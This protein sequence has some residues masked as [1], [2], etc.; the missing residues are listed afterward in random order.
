MNEIGPSVAPGQSMQG[1][2]AE[3]GRMMRDM[4]REM[5]ASMGD[6]DRYAKQLDS[7]KVFQTTR[8][9]KEFRDKF[10]T[11]MKA[12]SEI[13][14]TTQ[15]TV[16]DAM[17][18]FTD[19]RQQ[20]FYT[21][22][23]IKSQAAATKAREMTTGISAATYGAVGGAGAATARAYGMR[24]RFGA[25]LA[26]QNVAG[27]S[28]GIRS[29][30]MSEEEVME[31]GGVEAVGMRMSQQQMGFLR[32]SRGRAMLA[33]GMGGGGQVSQ[34]RMAQMLTGRGGV[35]QIVT[36]ASDRGLG[37]LMQAGT[38]EARE[39]AVPYA[40]MMMINM[41]MRQQRE[42]GQTVSRRGIV[43]MMGTMGVGRQEA[44]I[45]LQQAMG[46]PEQMRQERNAQ[47]F[48]ASQG[49]EA[50]L[51][52]EYSIGAR[53]GR[54][55]VGQAVTGAAR[56]LQETGGLLRQTGSQMYNQAM[57][58][59]T[60]GRVRT[61]SMGAETQ[62]ALRRGSSEFRYSTYE[63]SGTVEPMR[64]FVR[65]HSPFRI[66]PASDR[67]RNQYDDMAM[68]R[69]EIMSNNVGQ[70][71]T[72]AASDEEIAERVARGEF[73]DLGDGRLVKRTD[74]DKMDAI[75]AK[76]G[77]MSARNK[78]NLQ[79]SMARSD[80]VDRMKEMQ[81]DLRKRRGQYPEGA[82]D[83]DF[84]AYF[85]AV[86]AGIL[87]PEKSGGGFGDFMSEKNAD[88]RVRLKELVAR[89]SSKTQGPN[90]EELMGISRTARPSVVTEADLEKA[91]GS[92]DE[93][94]DRFMRMASPGLLGART[95]PLGISRG[96]AALRD[97]LQSNEGNV[98][99]G[100]NELMGLMGKTDDTSKARKLQL[101]DDL[102]GKM[103]P[104]EFKAIQD[105]YD[106]AEKDPEWGKGLGDSMDPKKHPSG[107]GGA[108]KRLEISE[109]THAR[110]KRGNK[111]VENLLA[112]GSF[113]DLRQKV[114]EF[115]EMGIADRDDFLEEMA[116]EFAVGGRDKKAGIGA[117]EQAILDAFGGTSAT[118]GAAG[119]SAALNAL[120]EGGEAGKAMAKKMGIT[121][122]KG[123]RGEKM[124]AKE[125]MGAL[126]ASGGTNVAGFQGG[127]G[128]EKSIEGIQKEYVEANTI[129]VSAVHTFASQVSSVPGMSA[130]V[131][132]ISAAP[133]SEGGADDG[134]K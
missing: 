59:I 78:T 104:L 119:L 60:G 37:T 71:E 130:W 22:A 133:G 54:T 82:S 85:G 2:G 101:L 21:T 77:Q 18:M 64:A 14:K 33:Y 61:R 49:R 113:E 44:E 86:E 79:L 90:R 124:S 31:M 53:L 87:D 69:S 80:Y 125:A 111:D 50:E 96:G 131:D 108:T 51:R 46:M 55:G 109:D 122:G 24:G 36:G 8:S 88:E 120:M 110:L 34:S 112:S 74:V 67:M 89:E 15:S 73:I 129:F 16:D 10:K 57:S 127:V 56:G 19:L 62:Q 5:G 27:V 117:D 35:E 118:G 9:A 103:S 83:A 4:S 81:G 115:R 11:V 1:Q 97:R 28:A 13:A 76:P 39:S 98:R 12:V 106:K 72:T 42:L 20:G 70:G 41:A 84:A 3:T 23:D 48:Q 123:A 95:G 26:Q 100:F 132:K 38:R 94:V 128:D 105:I 7:Q 17:N 92:Y 66:P 58:D 114:T 45:M 63:G 29:G 102:R 75:R 68:N 32:S 134:V 126:E 52:R 43:N 6:I 40:G 91:R 93:T 47:E 99:S 107:L 30:A 65:G 25:R 121:T 116:M